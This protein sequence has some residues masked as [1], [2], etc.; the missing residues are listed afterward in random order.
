M[1]AMKNPRNAR[2]MEKGMV[3]DPSRE[4]SHHDWKVALERS[5]DVRSVNDE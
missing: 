1:E 2:E 3:I 5:R 4:S